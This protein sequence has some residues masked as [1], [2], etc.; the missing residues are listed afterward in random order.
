MDY[1][2]IAGW[3]SEF[4]ERN[5]EISRRYT[6]IYG[7]PVITVLGYTTVKFEY[8]EIGECVQV[9]YFD[10]DGNEVY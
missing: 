4:D 6:G 9:R 8:N 5:N 3:E 7:E 10:A 2:G 1:A